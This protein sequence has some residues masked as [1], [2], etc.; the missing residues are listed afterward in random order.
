MLTW[1]GMRH[2]DGEVAARAGRP[3]DL[4]AACRVTKTDAFTA[5]GSPALIRSP[6]AALV[7]SPGKAR[8]A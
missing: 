1:E 4:H 3:G 2:L 8:L 5:R 7:G 6:I